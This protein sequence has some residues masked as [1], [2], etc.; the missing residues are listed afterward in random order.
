LLAR[1]VDFGVD[2]MTAILSSIRLLTFEGMSCNVMQC[3]AMSCHAMMCVVFVIVL[4]LMF[5][6]PDRNMSIIVNE[7]IM[8]VAALLSN[9]ND[10]IVTQA[11]FILGN[12]ARFSSAY[13]GLR[14]FVDREALDDLIRSS[15]E[16]SSVALL[17]NNLK[18]LLGL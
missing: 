13:S 1:G 11:L 4:I 18:F 6:H 12:L 10:Y 7:G 9:S 15:R 17:A 5:W 14:I 2:L 3:N 16:H 8:P